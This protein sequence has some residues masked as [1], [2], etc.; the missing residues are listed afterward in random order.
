M[1]RTL[2]SCACLVSLAVSHTQLDNQAPQ[3]S[4]LFIGTSNNNPIATTLVSHRPFLLHSLASLK[5]NEPEVNLPTD[6][7]DSGNGTD[8]SGPAHARLKAPSA[9]RATR[10]IF[11]M[12]EDDIQP[13]SM[14]AFRA[15][16]EAMADDAGRLKPLP[17]KASAELNQYLIDNIDDLRPPSLAQPLPDLNTM[18]EV[19][20]QVTNNPD[21]PVFQYATSHGLVRPQS[22]NLTLQTVHSRPLTSH[23]DQ[24]RGVASKVRDQVRNHVTDIGS[25]EELSVATATNSTLWAQTHALARSCMGVTTGV[26]LYD[27]HMAALTTGMASEL[28]DYLAE[29]TGIIK[30]LIVPVV[31]I[32]MTPVVEKLK[33]KMSSAG[34]NP[35]VD[36]LADLVFLPLVLLLSIATVNIVGKILPDQLL[37]SLVLRLTSFLAALLEKDVGSAVSQDMVSFI[38]LALRKIANPLLATSV[39]NFLISITPQ[40]LVDASATAVTEGVGTKTARMLQPQISSYLQCMYCYEKGMYC[41]QCWWNADL[42]WMQREWFLG[43]NPHIGALDFSEGSY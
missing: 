29:Q 34:S 8:I 16:K 15:I 3:S 37:D 33:Q 40:A 32:L 41:K 7:G 23:K 13:E 21:V 11:R 10:R 17:A 35:I 42:T 19:V 14:R 4:N 22:A 20:R 9:K 2:L 6:S 5:N 25:R 1:W 27:T 38:A 31:M 12:S 39:A 30:L 43:G 18:P 26:E 24:G 28:T 36:L